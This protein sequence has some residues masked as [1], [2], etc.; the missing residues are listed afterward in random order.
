MKLVPI[1]ERRI[2]LQKCSFPRSLDGR[3]IVF[4]FRCEFQRGTFL[5]L[6]AHVA[7]QMQRAFYVIDTSRYHDTCT[8]LADCF[9]ECLFESGQA[10]GRAVSFGTHLLDV[11]DVLGDSCTGDLAEDGIPLVV[12]GKTADGCCQPAKHQKESSVCHIWMF[13]YE[14]KLLFHHFL[15]T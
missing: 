12:I 3:K 11:D 10:V 7:N 8:S 14:L 6:Q 1:D 4:R 15:S 5:N 2:V 9:F 13:F